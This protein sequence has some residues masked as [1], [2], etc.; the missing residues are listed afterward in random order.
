PH[1]LAAVPE[2]F[3]G[4]DESRLNFV[5]HGTVGHPPSWSVP[6][7]CF[8]VA[9]PAADLDTLRPIKAGAPLP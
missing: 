5:F 3:F 8:A 1:R 6:T 7:H 9:F 4:F 2:S